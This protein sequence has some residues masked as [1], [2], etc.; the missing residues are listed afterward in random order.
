MTPFS[1]S[2]GAAV[3]GTRERRFGW[4]FLNT[5]LNFRTPSQLKRE[6]VAETLME[7]KT[8]RGLGWRLLYP[9]IRTGAF[10]R[11]NHE[12]VLEPLIEETCPLAIKLFISHRWAT[13]KDP[14]PRHKDVATVVGY[15]A[16]VFMI[17]N[18]FA[19]KDSLSIKELVI[20][21]QLCA[22]F[23]NSKVDRCR[24]GTTGWLDVRSLL[25]KEVFDDMFYREVLDIQ[26]RQNF[27]RLLKH[28]HVCGMIILLYRKGGGHRK[29]TRL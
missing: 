13:L 4:R 1:L 27:Y 2:S 24:C 28:V 15:L 10:P 22:G 9:F 19:S 5:I 3:Q 18:G 20:G 8:D 23:H 29:K 12:E 26:T 17:A 16:R 6:F 7:D 21:D 25:R 14:D 11:W